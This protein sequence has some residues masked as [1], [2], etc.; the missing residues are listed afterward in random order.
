VA[1]AVVAVVGLAVGLAVALGGGS[2]DEKLSIG[3]CVAQTIAEQGRDHVTELPED[4]EYSSTP[5]TSGTHHPQPAIWNVY[6]DPVEQMRLV[7]NL[8][9]GGIVVQYGED[10]PDA[11][12]AEIQSWYEQDPNGVIV[13][14]LPELGA[15]VA[16]TAWT[17]LLTCQGFNAEAFDK[18]TEEFR[19]KGPER[20]SPEAMQPGT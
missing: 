14:P 11:T 16:V 6:T 7:H 3:G 1:V 20:F 5:P 18:F 19:F 2:T 8:E 4:Y 12:V 15:Q 13:A 9:H 10:A 17:H